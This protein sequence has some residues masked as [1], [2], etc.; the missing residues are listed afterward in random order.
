MHVAS[1]VSR[2][3]DSEPSCCWGRDTQFQLQAIWP[4]HITGSPHVAR[5][6]NRMANIAQH[7][8]KHAH[9]IDTCARNCESCS[10]CYKARTPSG[11][12][13]YVTLHSPISCLKVGCMPLM[14]RHA[15]SN[16]RVIATDQ[17]PCSCETHVCQLCLIRTLNR[18]AGDSCRL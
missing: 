18:V 16:K 1:H 7:A 12:T 13:R 2:K 6:C 8:H 11:W 17:I 10:S 14:L 15:F 4:S 3:R 9:K 5:W